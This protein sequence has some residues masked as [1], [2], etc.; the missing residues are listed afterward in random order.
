M[1]ELQIVRRMLRGAMF[2]VPAGTPLAREVLGWARTRPSVLGAITAAEA[3]KLTWKALGRLLLDEAPGITEP[4][5]VLR[6]ADDFARLLRLDELD[7]AIVAILFAVDRQ[8]HPAELTSLLV[9]RGFSLPT[10]IGEAA[11]AEPQDAERRVRINP[12]VRHGLASFRMEAR[13]ELALEFRWTLRN[14]ID[15][16]P[17]DAAGIAEILVGPVQPAGLPLTAF[18]HVADSDF[19]VRL[20][21]GARREQASGINLLIHGPPGTG[22]TEL[23]RALAAAAGY[24]LH[25][26]GEAQED[27]DEPDRWDRIGALQMGQRLLAGSDA[28]LLFDEMEDL[29]GDAQPSQGDWL[30]GREGSKVFVNRLLETNPVP[31][32]WTTNAIGNVDPAILRRM[33]YVLKLDLPGRETA[34]RMLSHVAREDA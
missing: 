6:L 12:L 23:V 29:I 27:G 15:R 26:V 21:A 28:A 25:G 32:I 17:E 33:S 4:A 14:L 8:R 10:L 19:L 7:T 30:R 18:A 5:G 20:L 3:K 31:V 34:L 16:M 1:N 13:G 9:R 24:A 22:K 11:G 2:G